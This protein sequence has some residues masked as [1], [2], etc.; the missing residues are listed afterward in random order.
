MDE[1][2]GRLLL[3]AYHAAGYAALPLVPAF[4]GWRTRRGKEDPLRR[5]ERFGRPSL[6]RPRGRLVWIH[7]ASVGETNAVMPLVARIV[8]EGVGVLFTTV[9]LTGAKT[10]MGKLPKGAFHQYAPL[11]IGACIDRFLDNWRPDL[12]LFVESELWPATMGRLVRAKIPQVLVNARLS[13]RSFARWEKLGETARLLFGPVTLC[14]AQSEAD[15]ARYHRLG[16]EKVTV[17]GN[18]KFD[19]PPP[20]ADPRTVAAF[21]PLLAGRDVWVAASTHEGEEEVIAAA[22][23]VLRHRRRGLLTII[24]PRHPGRGP[25]VAAALAARGFAVALRSRDEPIRPETDIYLADTLGELGLF[26][27][28]A[29]IAFLGGSLVPH[30]GQNPIEPVR[31]DT[32]ILHGP[33]VHN[34]AEVYAA[35]DRTGRAETVRNSEGLATVLDALFSDPTAMRRRATKAAEALAAFSGALDATMRALLPYLRPIAIASGLDA[36][37]G[38]GG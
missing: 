28:L 30:G 27:R 25:E 13:E 16:V 12:A 14:L 24:V 20:F 22:H 23:R 18:L 8:D 26:Y 36:H 5:G 34:F 1:R 31:L 32:A 7:A 9:T 15:G 38:G 6:A 17:T 33:H 19:V 11:D 35:L 29:P 2:A 4:L 3:R 10:A 37:R 21:E